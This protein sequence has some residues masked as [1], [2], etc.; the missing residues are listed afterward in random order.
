MSRNAKIAG[1][2]ALGGIMLAVALAGSREPHEPQLEAVLPVLEEGEQEKRLAR[3]LER[4]ATLTMPD[5]GCEAAWA[6]KRRRF[7]GKDADAPAPGE[8]PA[9][10][11]AYDSDGSRADE[12]IRPELPGPFVPADQAGSTAP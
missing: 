8:H 10:P 7:F 2:A 6:E 9:L 1:V 3:E 11:A 12:A 5:S 4:C